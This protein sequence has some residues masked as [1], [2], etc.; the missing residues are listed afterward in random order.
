LLSFFTA[1][2]K[3]SVMFLP[4]SVTVALLSGLKVGAATPVVSTV[5]VALAAEPWLP[6]AS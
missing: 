3:V 2:A 4:A 5:K 1:S 6:A